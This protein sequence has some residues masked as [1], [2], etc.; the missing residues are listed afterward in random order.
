MLAAAFLVA[1][2]LHWCWEMVQ[3][4]AYAGIA[5]RT[6]ADTAW[7]CLIARPRAARDIISPSA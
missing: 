3:M 6:W 7:P 5:E 1:V 2:P 4:P